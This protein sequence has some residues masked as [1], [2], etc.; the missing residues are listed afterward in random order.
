MAVRVPGAIPIQTELH[1]YDLAVL[2]PQ[3]LVV[4]AEHLEPV[5]WFQL[6]SPDYIETV[7]RHDFLGNRIASM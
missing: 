7:R 5:A 1:V 4:Q 6:R 3:Y 2:D